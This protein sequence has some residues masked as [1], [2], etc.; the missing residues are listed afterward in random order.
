MYNVF[1]KLS[2]MVTSCILVTNLPFASSIITAQ[3]V[4]VYND[5]A[6]D[7]RWHL[8]DIDHDTDSV[9]TTAYP[10]WQIKC[11][12]VIVAGN[13]VV[14]GTSII[15]QIQ[16]VWGERFTPYKNV[17]YDAYNTT[18][19]TYVCHGTTLNFDCILAPPPSTADDI[20]KDCGEFLLGFTEKLGIQLGFEKCITDINA[21]Y[22]DVV[23]IVYFFESGINHKTLASIEKAFR[24]I[25]K[26][27]KDIGEAIL[28]CEAEGAILGNK[29][30]ELAKLLS[31]DVLSIIKI[32]IEDAVRIFYDRKEITDDC[33]NTVTHWRAGDFKG[34]GEAVGDI[35]GI[36]L[37][38]LN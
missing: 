2:K 12:S 4:C 21:T 15:P 28:V 38:E 19:I 7:L 8:H 3:S 14:D 26:M 20:A 13:K 27:I 35:V 5:A 29:I 18:Y 17:L 25:G 11:M 9:E 10:I 31:G 37:H 6:F 22:S 30:I 24:L 32:I 36:I 23:T 1:S 33:K 16:A 34:S